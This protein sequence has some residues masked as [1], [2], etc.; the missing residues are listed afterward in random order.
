MAIVV[1]ALAGADP[2][3]FLF[4]GLFFH[5]RLMLDL[6]FTSIIVVTVGWPIAY[7]FMRQHA[8]LESMAGKLKWAAH[9]DDLTKLTNR[10]TFIERA[11]ALVQSAGSGRGAGA[12]LYIDVDRFKS[13][14]DTHGHAAGDRA[15][16]ALAS[17]IRSCI[18][19]G[20]LA[21]RLGGEEFAVFLAGAD[22]EQANRVS[23]RI[24]QSV[25]AV[26][27]AI[28][29]E[30][31]VITVSIGMAMHIPGQSLDE[32]LSLADR[33]LYV[34]KQRGRDRVIDEDAFLTAA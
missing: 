12:L 14:N 13:I 10:R 7:F 8:E 23:Q 34:A 19:D 30:D 1:A 28:G 3:T 25:R 9:F 24:R 6:I 20:D 2:M 5:D 11:D 29:I 32:T 22:H 26:T 18:R 15:L 17:A 16:E 27:E 31:R 4:Y 21:G 33:Y